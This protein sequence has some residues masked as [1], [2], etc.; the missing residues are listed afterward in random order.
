MDTNKKTDEIQDKNNIEK[1]KNADQ[2]EDK[3]KIKKE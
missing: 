1:E 3:K 2:K